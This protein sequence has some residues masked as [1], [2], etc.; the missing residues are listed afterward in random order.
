[1][2]LINFD[3]LYDL[4]TFP[5]ID[6]YDGRLETADGKHMTVVGRARVRIALGAIDEEVNY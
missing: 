6:R 5:K 3:T 4:E 1:M 2:N